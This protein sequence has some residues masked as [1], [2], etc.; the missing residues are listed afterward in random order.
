M[1]EFTEFYDIH[2]NHFDQFNRGLSP[3][4][5]HRYLRSSFFCHCRP[6]LQVFF[7]KTPVSL[8][9]IRG[10]TLRPLQHTSTNYYLLLGVIESVTRDGDAHAHRCP[11]RW[12]GG[13]A[14][15]TAPSPRCWCSPRWSRAWTSRPP[16]SWRCSA[17]AVDK[18]L[19]AFRGQRISY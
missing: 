16:A 7:L 14:W 19:L 12:I 15:P 8:Q 13:S 11:R 17:W 6:C 18:L 1:N 5:I 9:S 10:I 4:W 2:T 3:P